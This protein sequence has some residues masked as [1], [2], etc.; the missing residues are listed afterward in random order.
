MVHHPE[1]FIGLELRVIKAK[2]K[3]LEQIFGK[4]IDET[5]KT[6]IIRTDQEEKIIL[7]QGT[8]FTI[9]NQIVSGDD[10]IQRPEDRIKKR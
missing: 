10:L 1:E 7:K 5:K 6:F 8:T 9:N 2:N 3:C 4:V